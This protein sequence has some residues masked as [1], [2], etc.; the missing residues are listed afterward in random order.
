MRVAILAAA[1]TA[2][3]FPA[4]A[5]PTLW[6]GNNH[7]YEFFTVT[8]T[9]ANAL[10]FAA[11]AGP[12]PAPGYSAPH[13]V[14]L[15]SAA[16][17]AWVSNTLVPSGINF[18]AAGTDEVTEGTWLWAAGPE[19]GLNFWNGGPGGSSPNFAFWNGGEPNNSGNEDYLVG[20]WSADLWNDLPGSSVNTYVV[21]WSRLEV[22]PTPAT[23]ALLLAGFGVLAAGRRRG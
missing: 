19:A 18:W 21:E 15:T 13:L 23:A 8:T 2:T 20:N 5:V 14:T 16:E 1:L 12:A 17:N 3:A 4:F 10:T 7:Y 9:W 11:A 6:A 22:V